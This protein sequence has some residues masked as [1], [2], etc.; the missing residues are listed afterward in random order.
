MN[1]W[2]KA[3]RLIHARSMINLNL[4]LKF[5]FVKFPDW[6]QIFAIVI[7]WI[8]ILR[9]TPTYEMNERGAEEWAPHYMDA[10][11]DYLFK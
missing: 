6:T 2:E 5:L 4:F 9:L 1:Q 10:A 3:T 7:M 11:A 8:D